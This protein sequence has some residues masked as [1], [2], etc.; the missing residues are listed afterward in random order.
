M[1]VTKDERERRELKYEQAGS[2]LFF[3]SQRQE[4]ERNQ[5]FHDISGYI[6]LHDDEVDR[7]GEFTMRS[8]VTSGPIPPIW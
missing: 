7:L 3:M 1:A 2:T 6:F 4:D 5:I 8:L